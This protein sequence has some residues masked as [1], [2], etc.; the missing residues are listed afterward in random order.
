MKIAIY[1]HELTTNEI[2]HIIMRVDAQILTVQT[3]Q[4]KPCIWV[5]CNLSNDRGQRKI[6]VF[7]TGDLS[8]I[9]DAYEKTLVYIGTFQLMDGRLVYHVFDGGYR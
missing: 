9:D 3:Q 7:P 1:K 6:Y 5:R 4:E 8:S 2:N